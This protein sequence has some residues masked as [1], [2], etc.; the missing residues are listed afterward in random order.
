MN[1]NEINPTEPL[2]TN[3]GMTQA[4]APTTHSPNTIRS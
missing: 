1:D 3:D 4:T 2:D